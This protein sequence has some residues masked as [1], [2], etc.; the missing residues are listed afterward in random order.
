MILR[1]NIYKVSKLTLTF[2]PSSLAR[3]GHLALG[4]RQITK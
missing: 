3:K 2:V 1:L 4:L